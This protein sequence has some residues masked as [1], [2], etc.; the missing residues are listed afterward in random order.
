MS[1]TDAYILVQC[2]HA[3]CKESV[4]IQLTALAGGGWDERYVDAELRSRDW[5]KRDDDDFCEEHSEEGGQP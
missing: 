3:G 2:D 1:R 4:E 5:T